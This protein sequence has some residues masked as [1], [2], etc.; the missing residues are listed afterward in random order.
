MSIDSEFA[1]VD[2]VAN[3][4]VATSGID[5][6]ALSIIKAERQIRR[7][8]THIVFQCPAF[9]RADIPTLRTALWENKQCYF[10]GFERGI[11]GFLPMPLDQLV[12]VHY[13]PL[14]LSID[15]AIEVRN[16]VFH[17]QLTNQSLSQPDL[18]V[19]VG[20]VRAWCQAIANAGT[21]AVGYDGFRRNSFRKG[22]VDVALTF[23]RTLPNV[24]EY[25]RFLREWVQRRQG[26]QPPQG[27]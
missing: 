6:F 12:G 25:R 3:A 2:L 18:L 14:R 26:W 1:T 7:L 5:A 16:K 8:F 10:E 23:K 22:R 4:G 11:D 9:T 21:Q 13:Q 19:H 15:D 20:N 27:W 24:A 17:G